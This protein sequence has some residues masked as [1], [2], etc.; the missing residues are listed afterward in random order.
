MDPYDKFRDFVEGGR[1]WAERTAPVERVS[2]PDATVTEGEAD[3][4]ARTKAYNQDYRLATIPYLGARIQEDAAYTGTDSVTSDEEAPRGPRVRSPTSTAKSEGA[5]AA[6][7]SNATASDSGAFNTRYS[8][9][10]FDD[11]VSTPLG[12]PRDFSEREHQEAPD[13]PGA[14][15][16]HAD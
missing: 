7:G 13:H 5:M 4:F 3:P 2:A 14:Q 15:D 10:R 6:G 1:P 12:S 9:K 11:F 8:S 16:V